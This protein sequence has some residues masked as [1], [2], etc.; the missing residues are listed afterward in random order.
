MLVM[1]IANIIFQWS[2]TSSVPTISLYVVAYNDY[3]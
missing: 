1:V 3:A 2:Y